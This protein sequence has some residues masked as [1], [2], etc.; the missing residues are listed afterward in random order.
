MTE[1]VEPQ[2]PIQEREVTDQDIELACDK[3]IKVRRLIK[4][5]DKH[6]SLRKPHVTPSPLWIKRGKKLEKLVMKEVI[7]TVT[8]IENINK[9]K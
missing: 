1:V 2:E 7:D 8:R 5:L 9:G 6:T 4:M 3:S